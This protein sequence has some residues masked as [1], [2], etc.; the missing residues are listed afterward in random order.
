MQYG[1]ELELKVIGRCL[2]AFNFIST[3]ATASLT[4]IFLVSEDRKEQM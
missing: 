4:A 3:A 1:V 2:A